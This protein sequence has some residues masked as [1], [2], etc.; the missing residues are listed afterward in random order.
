VQRTAVAANARLP[1]SPL[2]K[3]AAELQIS[4]AKILQ[5]RKA[6]NYFCF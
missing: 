3:Q 2:A 6:S 1:V 5:I 4:S